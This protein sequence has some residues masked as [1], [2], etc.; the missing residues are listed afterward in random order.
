MGPLESWTFYTTF[1]PWLLSGPSQGFSLLRRTQVLQLLHASS[2][3]LACPWFF[4]LLPSTS[5]WSCLCYVQPVHFWGWV[6]QIFPFCRYTR[7]SG[8]SELMAPKREVLGVTA[9]RCVTGDLSLHLATTSTINLLCASV[10]VDGASEFPA[11]C[12]RISYCRDLPCTEVPLSF[13]PD[14]FPF[15]IHMWSH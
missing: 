11:P 12:W 3:C 2:S 6:P 7:T 4:Q 14:F 9:G 13:T 5:R 15:G 1:R 10:L 8:V